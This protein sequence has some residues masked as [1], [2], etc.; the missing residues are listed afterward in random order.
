[1]ALTNPC[2]LSVQKTLD[3]IK[4]NVLKGNYNDRNAVMKGLMNDPTLNLTY[5]EATQVADYYYSIYR[6]IAN[7]NKKSGPIVHLSAAK[8]TEIQK[9]NLAL[10]YLSGNTATYPLTDADLDHVMEIYEKADKAKTPS[11]KARFDEEANVF[12]AKK[13]P[14]YSNDLFRS[15][16]YAR[17]L[18]S[19]VFFIK[20]LT[21]NFHSQIERA[22]ANTIWD[23]K[24]ADFTFLTR[25]DGLANATFVD[26]LK[27]G[28]PATTI[29]HNEQFD[30]SKGRLEESGFEGS[31]L[32][33]SNK[34]KRAYYSLMKFYT[35]W[36]NRYNAAPDTRGIYSNAER[37]MYQLLK[38]K[39][40]DLGMNDQ[41][42]TEKSL[43]DMELDDKANST[44]M[45]EAK[46]NELGLPITDK[47]GNSTSEFKVAVQEYQRLNRDHVIWS[48]AL[49]LSKNDFWKKNMTVA[50][51]QGFGDY[52][53]FGLQAQLFSAMKNKIESASKGKLSAAF[54]LY[55]FGFLNGAANFAEDA[56]ERMPIYA[57]VKLGFLQARKGNV[58]DQEL[59]RDIAR[60]QKDIIVKNVTTAAFFVGMKMIESLLCPGKKDKQSG[61]EIGQ[62]RTQVG[63][64]GIPVVVPPQ[65]MAM[66]KVWNIVN[67]ATNT[68]EEF[69]NTAMNILPVLV[70]SNQMG[71]GGTI[72]KLGTAGSEYA[73]TQVQGKASD[74]RD[75][76]SQA[77]LLKI[78]VRGGVDFANSFL[79]IP[80]RTMNEAGTLA[81]RVKGQ[82]QRQQDLTFSV[83][84]KGKPNSWFQT[85]GKTSIA[86]LGNVTGV[87][88]LIVAAIGSNKPYA[89]DWQGRKVVQL[90]GSDITGSGLDYNRNDE[91]LID[92]GVRPPYIPR[93]EKVDVSSTSKDKK[94][95]LPVNVEEIKKQVR[96]LTDEEF[97]NVS[98]VLSEFNAEYFDKKYDEYRALVD[99]DKVLAKQQ[100]ETVFRRTKDQAIKAIEAGVT[101]P[102][103]ILKWVKENW[104]PTR[105]QKVTETTF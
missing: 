15:S 72:D 39:Y 37:H 69:F 13:L 95:V 3:I 22:I 11:L 59:A 79:P 100:I 32:E 46:F 17:P 91:L 67:Q 48:K 38:E 57:L 26:V 88:E 80:S 24:K 18:L 33:T 99:K 44:R 62:G 61:Y 89:M 63:P 5:S 47:K 81:Q 34:A 14:S 104:E 9:N 36:S 29:A 102:D 35:K 40:R 97:Y 12:I 82:N 28:I 55:A 58:T 4:D 92:A 65:M 54:N 103:K 101:D 52:G 78:A 23:G 20:S 98:K 45:A 51:E 96:Y 77:K 19:A 25:F 73:S 7:Q 86:S 85:L 42:A 94:G 64:C 41:D 50:S 87:N 8:R 105:E 75:E 53:V 21:S 90:R 76:E 30:F 93:T 66:Y 6:K 74:V 56:I 1:M 10:D 49:E 84:D 70:Q 31:S 43:Q 60:R 71:L 83:D 2:G 27:G 68:D 16:V